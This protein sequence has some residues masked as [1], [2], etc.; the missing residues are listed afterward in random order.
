MSAATPKK[1]PRVRVDIRSPGTRDQGILQ[2]RAG[3]GDDS[4]EKVA[5]E[6]QRDIALDDQVNVRDRSFA[7]CQ[8]GVKTPLVQRRFEVG[9]SLERGFERL[10]VRRLKGF[11]VTR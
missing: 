2:L 10:G 1:A 5:R 4:L 9:P 3:F 7:G 8:R 6:R 11:D